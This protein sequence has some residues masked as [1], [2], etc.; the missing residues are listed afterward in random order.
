MKGNSMAIC[1]ECGHR[2]SVH[3]DLGCA[4]PIAVAG[5]RTIYCGCPWLMV[6]VAVYPQRRTAA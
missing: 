4:T 2:G 6:R 5:K 3:D 1:A